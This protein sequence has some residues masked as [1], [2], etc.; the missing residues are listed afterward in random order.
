M[1]FAMKLFRISFKLRRSTWVLLGFILILSFVYGALRFQEKTFDKK[2]FQQLSAKNELLHQALNT[3]TQASLAL[4]R[5]VSLGEQ[6]V[7]AL[8]AKTF[9]QMGQVRFLLEAIRNKSSL[10]NV[11]I[12]I[13]DE[14]G[15]VLWGSTSKK[16]M[17]P[18]LFQLG[19]LGESY[20]FS[21]SEGSFFHHYTLEG[22]APILK[23]GKVSGLVHLELPIDKAFL[24]T[25]KD[26]VQE[27]IFLFGNTRWQDESLDESSRMEYLSL[28]RQD[29]VQSQIKTAY[30]ELSAQRTKK[31]QL[32]LTPTASLGMVPLRG[33]GGEVVSLFVVVIPNQGVFPYSE[34]IK[35]TILWGVGLLVAFLLFRLVVFFALQIT[36]LSAQTT[37][38]VFVG[39]LATLGLVW[40][41]SL[42]LEA[43]MSQTLQIKNEK[44]VQDVSKAFQDYNTYLVNSIGDD[45]EQLKQSFIRFLRGDPIPK[46]S[47]Y[48]FVQLPLGFKKKV[49]SRVTASRV[50]LRWSGQGI[51]SEKADEP[52]DRETGVYKVPVGRFAQKIW[53]IYSS[54]WGYPNK[55]GSP[56]GTKIG[57]VKIFFENG[58]SFEVDLENGVNI[59]DRFSPLEVS[60]GEESKKAFDFIS[61]EDP[62]TRLQYVEEL[63]ITIP[64]LY[65]ES[66][67]DYLLFQDNSTPD[68]P[69]F[70][71]VTLGVKKVPAFPTAFP[72][73]QETEKIIRLKDPYL[74]KLENASLVYF[75]GDRIAEFAFQDPSRLALTG[76]QAPERIGQ[77]V[78]QKKKSTFEKTSFYGFPSAVT[79][80]PLQENSFENPWGMIAV[81]TPAW[82]LE[83]LRQTSNVVQ[84]VLVILLLILGV[85]AVG[86]FIISLKK[87][88]FKLI[89]YSF[90][91][92]F[93]PLF[94]VVTLLGYLIWQRE[95]TAAQNRVA[96][97]LEQ[98]K[99]FLSDLQKK[100]EELALLLSGRE[101]LIVAIKEN[102][103]DK[104]LR[105]LNEAK[106]SGLADFTGG[107]IV[108]KYS[109]GV[110]PTRLW[111]TFNFPALP[112]STKRLLEN[113]RSGVFVNQV[114]SLVM[115]VSQLGLS[116]IGEI[117]GPGQLSIQVG[118]PIDQIFLSEMKRR[119][120]SDLA[121]YS[122]DALKATTMNLANPNST[123]QIRSLARRQFASLIKERKN[124]FESVRIDGK[125]GMSFLH[126]T[127]IG[128]MPIKD[129]SNRLVGMLAAFSAHEKSILPAFSTQKV[130]VFSA[131]FILALAGLMSMIISRSITSPIAVLAKRADSI[132]QG[133][134]GSSIHVQTQDEIGNLAQSF[135]YMSASL[136]ENRDQL[137][138]KI[139]DLITLQKLSSR[140]SSVLEKEELRHLIVKL[141]CELAGF[142]KGMLL[143]RDEEHFVV[144]SGQGVRNI[145]FGKVRYLPEETLAGLCVKERSL[146]F[147]ENHLQDKRIP[148]QSVHRRLNEKPMMILALPLMVKGKELGAVVLERPL[149]KEGLPQVDEALIMTL[150]NHAAIAL[151]NAHLYEMAVEDGLTKV[152]V[153]RYFQF[154]LK[155]EVEHAKRYKTDLSLVLIDLDSF[156]PINDNYGHQVG[157]KILISAAQIMKKTFR[158][159]DVVCRYGGD[160]FVVIL[161]KT[162][163][164]EAVHIAER[165][166]QEVE[167]LDFQSGTNI[168][169]RVTLSI[170]IATWE[171]SMEK[172]ALIKAADTAL[173]V[174]KTGGRNR[175]SRKE[176]TA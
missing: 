101:E 149:D 110:E 139:K 84:G 166:R 174:A 85:V 77:E 35:K 108:V 122:A 103:K 36:T 156:K 120:G 44:L 69:L 49:V 46:P 143:V 146:V 57:S 129:E 145:E 165:L 164:D 65:T 41:T 150:A 109:R 124:Q 12:S 67:I 33:L 144:E 157:D 6:V 83:R 91:V 40:V 3:T 116:Q 20:L 60:A 152:F 50:P 140:V 111:S 87:L 43:Y 172:D 168:I 121:F 94:L 28:L 104:V 127:A 148:H 134:L 118:V 79:Y 93:V 22:I 18:S 27:E 142:P 7:S 5:E 80:W 55:F 37:I 63:E 16:N 102:N 26:T 48:E 112:Y 106:L 72:T 160:E 11:R 138:Q 162:S 95:E 81:V 153:N 74:S 42:G 75:K 88:R 126:R 73:I 59:H 125:K 90:L 113:G 100:V 173:Y 14:K 39:V 68:V 158:S 54:A 31:E 38:W 115:G 176:Q 141:F 17:D 130:F 21:R 119:I 32:S 97:S 128:T 30:L 51:F 4:M 123:Q 34:A 53:L 155:E 29:S 58:N 131:I 71:A 78:L 52:F 154:R 99:V 45:R 96:T 89:S 159:T 167:R 13:L 70:Y 1:L 117:S 23:K 15:V 2:R 135:N 66:K 151:E 92:S 132:A 56:Y 133:K 137:E 175:V 105:L 163:G 169:L 25:L 64:P 107:F 136:K 19:L 9:N 8:Q 170:G 62:L 171:P 114:A 10:Q 24:S 76:T 147:V 161:P 98:S 47:Q 86:N 82:T 61:S